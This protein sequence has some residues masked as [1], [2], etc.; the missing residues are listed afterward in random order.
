VSALW[1][2]VSTLTTQESGALVVVSTC[3]IVESVLDVCDVEEFA[4]EES[5]TIEANTIAIIVR[6]FIS[7]FL[8]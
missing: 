5:A 6:F 2:A 1:L 4:H 3:V 7:V 8:I